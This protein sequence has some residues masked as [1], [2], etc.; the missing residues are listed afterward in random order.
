M[1]AQAPHPRPQAAAV[2]PGLAA[3]DESVVLAA[4]HWDAR[5]KYRAAARDF[6]SAVGLDF[7]WA[8]AGPLAGQG[9][10][11]P[12]RQ[13]Q[14]RPA[15]LQKVACLEPQLLVESAWPRAA[16]EQAPGGWVSAR[17]QVPQASR[18]QGCLPAQELVHWEQFSDSQGLLQE[19][20][21]EQG[22]REWQGPPV[23]PRVG[24]V[25]SEQSA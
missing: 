11:L 21:P 6:L 7:Q 16:R 18:L 19:L 13:A 2:Y 20:P 1:G 5:E 15:A 10:G 3:A 22:S 17:P 24:Q 8:V 25:R 14:R 9:D 4:A 23:W 12:E